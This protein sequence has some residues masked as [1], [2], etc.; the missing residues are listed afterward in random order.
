MSLVHHFGRVQRLRPSEK[1]QDLL[2][3]SGEVS[4][5][6]Y[7]QALNRLVKRY[8]SFLES[9]TW[10]PDYESKPP[11]VD[12][13]VCIDLA[14]EIA[15]ECGI[16]IHSQS[17]QKIGG[18]LWNAYLNFFKKR[19][20]KPKFKRRKNGYTLHFPQIKPEHILRD[21]I[22]IPGVGWV[23]L[24][25]S[26]SLDDI[27]G[28]GRT[29]KSIVVKFDGDSYTVSIAVKSAYIKPEKPTGEPVALDRGINATATCSDGTVFHAPVAKPKE[30]RRF[31]IRHRRISRK[32]KGSNNY[33][34]SVSRARITKQKV[35]RR[36]NDA[37]H[38]FTTGLAKAKPVIV[39]EDLHIRGMTASAAGTIDE[40]GTN[41]KQK[42][43]LNRSILEHKWGFILECLKYKCLKFGGAVFSVP[44]KHT[45]QTCAVCGHVDA[46]SRHRLRFH[47]TACHHENNAD[48]NA[49]IVIR[50]R[51]EK[52]LG[53]NITNVP[54]E[55]RKRT[56]RK[57]PVNAR[58]DM[59]VVEDQS[60]Q[61]VNLI[62]TA[63]SC[64]DAGIPVLGALSSGY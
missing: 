33:D 60:I 30:R 47:C 16:E 38:K 37:I 45:S 13:Y 21:K 32:E 8:E 49:S 63:P 42:S 54:E 20:N 53:K 17:V 40:P 43:G 51:W 39:V 11:K 59:N 24:V 46:K 55:D 64:D 48:N 22:K 15:R 28:P 41:V 50:Q 2:D 9:T 31:K 4:R 26:F 34:K 23:K 25:N 14:T 12:K 36:V 44:A 58:G 35:I 18:H 6:I 61:P 57:K 1:Q 5:F 52:G 27:K 19:S 56:W 29:P 10:E 62:V 7:N 3:G